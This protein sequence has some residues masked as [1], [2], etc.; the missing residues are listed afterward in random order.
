M[1]LRMNPS[2][3]RKIFVKFVEVV[4][5]QQT[6]RLDQPPTLLKTN[7]LIGVFQVFTEIL[8]AVQEILVAISVIFANAL[9]TRKKWNRQLT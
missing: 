1:N 7:R 8:T 9:E 5:F 6:F 3:L 4:S 2:S